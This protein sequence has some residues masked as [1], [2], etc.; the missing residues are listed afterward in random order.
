M[1]QCE[2]VQGLM[3]A[4]GSENESGRVLV[5]V[6]VCEGAR[7]VALHVMRAG[8]SGGNCSQREREYRFI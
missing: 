7:L 6:H 4:T 2:W 1:S 3:R 8:R 5:C